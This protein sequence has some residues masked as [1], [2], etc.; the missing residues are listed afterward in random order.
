MRSYRE[1][2][3]RQRCNGHWDTSSFRSRQ[4]PLGLNISKSAESNLPKWPCES[5]HHWTTYR[6]LIWYPGWN[7]YGNAPLFGLRAGG[8]LLKFDPIFRFWTTTVNISPSTVNWWKSNLLQLSLSWSKIKHCAE[9]RAN[10][11]KNCSWLCN[12]WAHIFQQS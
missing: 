12:Y 8:C 7:V 2:K 10:K 6:R 11:Y 1:C 3:A 4:V 5:D 9:T